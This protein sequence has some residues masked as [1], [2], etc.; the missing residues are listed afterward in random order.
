MT[1]PLPYTVGDDQDPIQGNFDFIK[2]RF[3]LSRKDM[4]V[5]TPHNVGDAEEPAFAN[6][7]VNEDPTTLTRARFWRDAVGQ[8]HV[9]GVIQS[10]TIG[11]AAFT[12][13]EGYRPA[14]GIPPAAAATNTGYGEVRVAPTGE[15]IPQSGGNGYFSFAVHFRQE[16]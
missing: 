11:S 9:E 4:K 2:N 8:V 1:L 13:P 6:S 15:V 5:E 7:W 10:G 16:S 14:P 3:P 12:L